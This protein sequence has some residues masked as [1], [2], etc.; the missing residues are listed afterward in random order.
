MRSGL[1][2]SPIILTAFYAVVLLCGTGRVFGQSGTPIELNDLSAF[3]SPSKNWQIVG[4]AKADLAKPSSLTFIKG[5]GVLVNLPDKKNV[6]EDLYTI[7]E[8]GDIDLELD[9]LMAPGSNSGIYLQGD[10]KSVV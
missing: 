1:K 10:R 2:I 3:K 9:Y 6:G 5:A 8:Y 7:A 4:A